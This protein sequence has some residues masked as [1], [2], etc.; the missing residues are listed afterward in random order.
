MT[1]SARLA[2]TALLAW[3]RPLRDDPWSRQR[4]TGPSLVHP[5]IPV[6]KWL[7][8]TSFCHRSLCPEVHEYGFSLTP[9]EQLYTPHTPTPHPRRDVQKEEMDFLKQCLW[10][11]CSRR[12]SSVHFSEIAHEQRVQ[13]CSQRPNLRRA[14]A[15]ESNKSFLQKNT[16]SRDDRIPRVG[17]EGYFYSGLQS[18]LERKRIAVATSIHSCGSR[19]VHSLNPELS[20][21]R[22]RLRKKRGKVCSEILLPKT[23]FQVVPI[24]IGRIVVVRSKGMLLVCIVRN[25]FSADGKTP[26]ER[27]F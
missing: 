2:E 12:T 20:I 27:R 18:C 19:S 7:C 23:K 22:L 6:M 13:S 25:I 5:N 1:G 8:G 14:Q 9:C 4:C 26:F 10:R 15:H 16:E 24:R 3:R 11:Q 17:N 21:V